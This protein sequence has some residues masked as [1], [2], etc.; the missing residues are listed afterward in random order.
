MDEPVITLKGAC[1]SSTPSK[2]CI[3]SLTREQFE[4]L[5]NA[6]QPPE[7]GAVPPDVRRRFASQYAKLLTEADA[8]RQLGL[9][10]DP[11]VLEI[12]NF[13]KTSILA[14]ALSEHYM[15][16]FAHP[17]DQQIQKYYDDNVK[18]YREVTLQRIIIPVNQGNADKPKP[19]EAEV[20]AYADKIHERW[21][22]G[23]DANKLQKEAMEHSGITTSSPD[24]NIGA[25]RPGSLPVAHETIFD[26]KAN[27]VSQPFSDA[28]AIYMYKILSVRQV[29][30][31][32][33]K[34]SIEQAL[35]REMFNDKMQQVQ[36]TGTPVL[37]DA[38]FGPEPPPTPPRN[39]RPGGPPM[40]GAGA[41]PPPP[42]APGAGATATPPPPPAANS[43]AS[44]K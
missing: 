11:K 37:N 7:K 13:A 26:L 20:K 1:Q 36:S 16:E 18:K 35:Q 42:L 9:E 15:Q 31:S 23:E 39:I 2:D 40:P 32:E 41:A 3:T 25:R 21:V 29:P 34:T 38:Y 33:V 12:Y 28:A 43:G 4:K 6:L 5:T 27:D 24:V 17:S 44:P 10:N 19:T 22:A 30:L 14:E 8:A